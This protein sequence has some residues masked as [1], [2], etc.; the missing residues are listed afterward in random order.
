MFL[1]WQGGDKLNKIA[2]LYSYRKEDVAI[3]KKLDVDIKVI[4]CRLKKEE[5]THLSSSED[6]SGREPYSLT[7]EF[8]CLIEDIQ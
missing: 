5:E 1:W 7:K 2:C 4:F 6:P 3:E 8:T